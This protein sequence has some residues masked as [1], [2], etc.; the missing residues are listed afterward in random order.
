MAW[1]SLVLSQF[2]T[3][4]G[5]YEALFCAGLKQSGFSGV[6]QKMALH[7]CEESMLFAQKLIHLHNLDVKLRIS[8]EC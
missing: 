6:C 4:L 5:S 3:V 2:G 1:L 8:L 7:C